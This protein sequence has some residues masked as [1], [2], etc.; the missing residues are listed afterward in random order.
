MFPGKEQFGRYDLNA[1]EADLVIYGNAS[2]AQFGWDVDGLGDTNGNGTVDILDILKI[3]TS[4]KGFAS[5][6]T[7]AEWTD[8]DFVGA[9]LAAPANGTVD[10]LDILAVKQLGLFGTGSYIDGASPAMAYNAVPEPGTLAMLALGLIGLLVW[11][12]KRI[13]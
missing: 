5:Q 4:P 9:S 12:R 6:A 11:R 3:K 2:N 1:S 13:A 8:G 10:I 7:D